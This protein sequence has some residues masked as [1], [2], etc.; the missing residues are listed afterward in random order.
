MKTIILLVL[1]CYSSYSIFAQE[2]DIMKTRSSK[3]K[4]KMKPQP[5]DYPGFT[6]NAN[7]NT[8][9][10]NTKAPVSTTDKPLVTTNDKGRL[11]AH[12]HWRQSWLT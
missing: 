10:S 12:F 7:S 11:A 3:I 5:G 1:T 6:N 9:H 4:I 8:I 2:T